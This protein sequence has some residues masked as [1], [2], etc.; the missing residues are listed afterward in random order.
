MY[1]T[2]RP[3]LL[4]IGTLIQDGRYVVEEFIGQGG[5]GQVYRVRQQS[6]G[7]SRALKLLAPHD[8]RRATEFYDTF[9]NEVQH[10]LKLTHRNI[11]KILD[12]DPLGV[13]P[14]SAES[15]SSGKHPYYIM[16][17]AEGQLKSVAVPMIATKEILLDVLY[18]IFDGLVYAH[19]SGVY[20]SDVKPSNMLCQVGATGIEVKVSDL[21]VSKLLEPVAGYEATTAHDTLLHSTPNYAAPQIRRRI[22]KGERITREEIRQKNELYE[23]YTL[24]I[25]LAEILSVDDLEGDASLDELNR[26]LSLMQPNIRE[27]F[28]AEEF[29]YFSNFVRRLAADKEEDRYQSVADAGKALRRIE[30]RNIAFGAIPD[31]T[32]IGCKKEINNGHRRIRFSDAA[33]RWIGHPA[34]QRLHNLNQLNFVYLV[35][36]GAKHSRFAHSLEAFETARDF[37]HHLLN[38]ATFR[39]AVNEDDIS[40]FLAASLL[41]DVG[42]YPLAHAIDEIRAKRSLNRDSETAHVRTDS[43]MLKHFLKLEFGRGRRLPQKTLWSMLEDDR[44]DPSR[45][46]DV[47]TRA[48]TTSTSDRILQCLLNGSID[49]DKV[50]YLRIDSEQ[51]EV[52]YGNGIDLAGLLPALR[53]VLPTDSHNGIKSP[54]LA[55]IPQGVSA[56]E[57]VITARLHMYDRVYWHR[58]N[59]AIMAMIGYVVRHL[60]DPSKNLLGFYDYINATL[61][62]SDIEALR[63]LSARMDSAIDKKCFDNTQ[64]ALPVGNPLHGLIHNSRELH[65]SLITISAAVEPRKH[66]YLAS[67]DIGEQEALRY[68]IARAIH[69]SHPE[70]SISDDEVLFDIPRKDLSSE[71]QFQDLIVIDPDNRMDFQL[72]AYSGIAK[73]T[74]EEYNKRASR[75]RVFVSPRIADQLSIDDTLKRQIMELLPDTR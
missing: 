24:G 63:W 7:I 23:N 19:A 53:I 44:I 9:G 31:L 57:S 16:E 74:Q 4:E 33:F 48:K 68:E 70:L 52:S 46:V 15:R 54:Q 58:A 35:Y 10:L 64:M 37:A 65:K 30:P 26:L 17:H 6:L 14:T 3:P 39:F 13:E 5:A 51:T 49:V 40:L 8:E 60:L 71:A 59:R 55:I 34:F 72:T 41:H 75:C 18:Q 73:A 47:V 2:Q 38:D 62:M 50:A 12:Y 21:G 29:Q 43:E 61:E 66:S 1:R 11:I 56:A 27:L 22:R 36:P 42:H 28:T 25:A 20:H 32:G 45:L 67:C 69:V